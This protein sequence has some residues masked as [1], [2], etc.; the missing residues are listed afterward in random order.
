MMATIV[1][2]L[3]YTAMRTSAECL[4]KA[5]DMECRAAEC[6]EGG[7]RDGFKRMARDWRGLANRAARQDGWAVTN[8]TTRL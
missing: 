6:P 4:A 2:P 7:V 5:D 3:S 8:K 1:T